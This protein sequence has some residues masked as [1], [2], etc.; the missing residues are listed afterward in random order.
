MSPS[1]FEVVRL[2]EP[3][4]ST[5][6]SMSQKDVEAVKTEI[7]KRFPEWVKN[8]VLSVG[9]T[10]DKSSLQLSFVYERMR[11]DDSIATV[12]LPPGA[13]PKF[14]EPI[15]G[16]MGNDAFDGKP[17]GLLTVNVAGGS[18]ELKRINDNSYELSSD[19]FI[20]RT[21]LY[22]KVFGVGSSQP[23]GSRGF[24]YGGLPN[25]EYKLYGDSKDNYITVK[26][27]STTSYAIDWKRADIF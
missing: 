5:F 20:V 2:P 11:G 3:A 22:P 4:H 19:Q 10:P 7:A 13:F 21:D 14:G 15:Y 23:P 12:T 6:S 1:P 8:E 26:M 17:I 18:T 25:S 16:L 9:L 24:N 27:P